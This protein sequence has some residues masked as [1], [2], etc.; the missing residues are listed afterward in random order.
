MFIVLLLIINFFQ[1][2][3]YFSLLWN[4]FVP[5]PTHWST[6]LHIVTYYLSNHL[7]LPPNCSTCKD[8]TNS[9]HT[10]QCSRNEGAIFETERSSFAS[11]VSDTEVSR[12][13]DRKTKVL[14]QQ[15]IIA[16]QNF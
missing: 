9:D 6:N 13:P 3:S 15:P 4:Q 12:S 7:R 2:L 1:F 14:T 8:L 16:T 10:C 5:F 11:S